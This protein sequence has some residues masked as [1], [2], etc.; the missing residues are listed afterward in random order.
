MVIGMRLHSL[1]YAANL[2]IPMVGL[3]YEQKVGFFMQS[4][5]QPYVDW[6]E[7]FNMDELLKNLNEVWENSGMIKRELERFKPRLEKMVKD[8]VELTL[9]FLPGKQK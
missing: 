5:N 8:S 3:A 7:N 2:N 4:I 1:I 9:S 6:N